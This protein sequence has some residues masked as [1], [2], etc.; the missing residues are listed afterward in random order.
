MASPELLP[1]VAAHRLPRRRHAAA[2]QHDAGEHPEREGRPPGITLAG[3][4]AQASATSVD[5]F[6]EG[7]TETIGP[8]S[9]E[10]TFNVSPVNDE[11]NNDVWILQDATYGVYDA[12]RLAY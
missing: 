4:P 3:L 11:L 10:F 5:F 7:Y 12:H 6:I 8:A 1:A 9:Y 2:E